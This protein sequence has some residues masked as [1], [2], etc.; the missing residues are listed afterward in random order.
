MQV[1][2]P[3]RTSIIRFAK[4]HFEN[5]YFSKM[6]VGIETLLRMRGGQC[7][8]RVACKKTLSSITGLLPPVCNHLHARVARDKVQQSFFCKEKSDGRGKRAC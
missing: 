6:C 2:Q 8:K 5:K 3:L 7:S 1:S 4:C